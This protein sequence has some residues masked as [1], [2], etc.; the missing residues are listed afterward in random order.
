MSEP[1][2]KPR[3]QTVTERV[4]TLEIQVSEL[5][6]KMTDVT[7]KMDALTGYQKQLYEYLLKM[8]K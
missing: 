3:K 2:E 1:V 8:K 5:S 6:K 4:T 7:T